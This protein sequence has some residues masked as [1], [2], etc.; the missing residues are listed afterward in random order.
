MVSNI[1]FFWYI[2]QSRDEQNAAWET[3]AEVKQVEFKY[4]INTELK[5]EKRWTRGKRAQTQSFQ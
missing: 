2:I 4:V 5:W 3:A 1:D